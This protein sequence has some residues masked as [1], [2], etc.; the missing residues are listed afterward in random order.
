I[1][2]FIHRHGRGP[3]AFY[4]ATA[5]PD[6]SW[7]IITAPHRFWG[8]GPAPRRG[9]KLLLLIASVAAVSLFSSYAMLRPIRQFTEAFR[10]FGHDP[11]AAPLPEVGPR[12]LRGARASFNA[13]QAQIQALVEARTA[14]FAAISHDL[15]TPLTKMRL[16]GEFIDD[17]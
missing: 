5:L 4:L 11:R 6:G 14:V 1:Q 9:I 2:Q 3:E 12:E 10:R 7:M 16:R 15:R 13:M 17:P 8:L